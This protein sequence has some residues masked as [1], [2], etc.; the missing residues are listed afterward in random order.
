MNPTELAFA[1][2]LSPLK[3]AFFQHPGF[4]SLF[5]RLFLSKNIDKYR[6]WP[7]PRR[8]FLRGNLGDGLA[9]CL[10]WFERVGITHT[11]SKKHG[12]RPPPKNKTDPH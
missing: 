2:S 12:T 8:F 4:G 1:L 7:W 5:R 6:V 3:A 11:N 10:S 9:P